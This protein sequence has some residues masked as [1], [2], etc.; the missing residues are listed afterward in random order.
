MKIGIS[1]LIARQP[2]TGVENAAFNLVRE[3]HALEPKAEIIVYANTRLFPWL[4]HLSP[5]LQIVDVRLPSRRLLWLWENLFFLFDRRAAELDVV[6]FP[7]GFGVL[8]YSGRFVLTMHDLKH[9]ANRDLVLLR[10]HL[11][12]RIW[13]KFNVRKAEKIITVSE[14]VKKNILHAFPIPSSDVC[15]ISNGVD[16]RFTARPQSQAFRERYRLPERYVLFVGQT[17]MNKNLRRAIDA[18]VIILKSRASDHCFVIA[19]NAGEADASLKDYVRDNHLGEMIRFVGYVEDNDLPQLYSNA[20]LFLFP[21][22][23]EGFGIP[24]LEAMRSGI[25]TV[26]AHATSL[27]EVLGDAAIWVD[28]L[29]VD[30]IVEGVNAALFDQNVRSQAVARGFAKARQYSWRRMALETLNVYREAG[31]NP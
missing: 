15:V 24:P 27:P 1:L 26:A 14:Y 20:V 11:L 19:G 30:S 17:S 31:S 9:Y 29:S 13:C 2:A 12:W 3:L 25:P 4:R 6:H 5:G 23:A 18:M 28:P 22:I 7:I 21:S 10:R 8:G 16:E